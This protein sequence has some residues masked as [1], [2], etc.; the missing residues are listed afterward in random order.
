MDTAPYLKD[1]SIK[2]SNLITEYKNKYKRHKQIYYIE[3]RKKII[4]N[5]LR[6]YTKISK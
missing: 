5:R 6:Q 2:E 1:N 4:E 3:N